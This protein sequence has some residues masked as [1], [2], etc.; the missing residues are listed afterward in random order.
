MN[1]LTKTNGRVRFV[2]GK[3][4]FECPSVFFYFLQNHSVNHS[5]VPLNDFSI[6]IVKKQKNIK[7]LLN[8]KS[9]TANSS[10][11]LDKKIFLAQLIKLYNVKKKPVS[12][13]CMRGNQL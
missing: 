11:Q 9:G 4:Q 3:F 8:P 5:S 10:Q 7:N 6:S 13:A 1:L 12:R 2:D